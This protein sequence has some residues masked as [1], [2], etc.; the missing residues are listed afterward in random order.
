MRVAPRD[1]EDP[2]FPATRSGG[3]ERTEEDGVLYYKNDGDED[4]SRFALTDDRKER[5]SRK[6]AKEM[7]RDIKARQR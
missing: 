3:A 1:S 2:R 6:Q 7:E 4:E 5:K